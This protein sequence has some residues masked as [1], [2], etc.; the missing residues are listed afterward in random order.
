MNIRANVLIAVHL[1]QWWEDMAIERYRKHAATGTI[2]SG[3]SLSEAQAERS[4]RDG[5]EAPLLDSARCAEETGASVHILDCFSDPG[6]EYLAS[7]LNAP[8]VGVGHAG[9][10]YAH[11][12]FRRFAVISS[13]W[14]TVDEIR[15]H[16][17]SYDL[18]VRLGAVE[19]V[20]ISAA[21]L[22][23]RQE[24]ALSRLTKIGQALPS[25][26]EG[27]IM[28]CTELAE[29]AVPLEARLKDQQIHVVNPIAVAMQFAEMRSLNTC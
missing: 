7:R 28:G 3:S 18:D 1:P 20:G 15:S 17:L 4:L 14:A 2:V 5:V 11:G 13:E 10:L 27:I 29:L 23:T 9:L 8:V 26:T 24:E 6:M 16:A 21:E 22:P 19:C 25:D 12:M